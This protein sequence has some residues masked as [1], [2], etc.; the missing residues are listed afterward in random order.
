[1]R[2]YVAIANVFS[3]IALERAKT[4]GLHLTVKPLN[5]VLR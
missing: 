5:D 3:E 2:F 1:M 4:H